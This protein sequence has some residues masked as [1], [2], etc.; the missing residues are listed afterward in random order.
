MIP[1]IHAAPA[2]PPPD[3]TSA[4]LGVVIMIILLPMRVT[5]IA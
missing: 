4:L 2:F 1:A 3:S 5:R